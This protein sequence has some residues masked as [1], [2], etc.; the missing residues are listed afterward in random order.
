MKSRFNLGPL[1]Y[2]LDIKLKSKKALSGLNYV[3][4]IVWLAT[5]I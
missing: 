1:N 2:F 5:I 4:N 3:K